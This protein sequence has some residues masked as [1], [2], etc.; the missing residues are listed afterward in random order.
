MSSH[1]VS[2]RHDKGSK[3]IKMALIARVTVVK[4]KPNHV[5]IVATKEMDG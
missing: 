4:V 2:N 5:A 1:V 3:C